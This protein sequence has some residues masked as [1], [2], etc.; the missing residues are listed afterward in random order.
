MIFFN[1]FV[2]NNKNIQYITIITLGLSRQISILSEIAKTV[3]K[4][5]KKC[6]YLKNKYKISRKIFSTMT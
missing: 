5:V 2:H 3:L 4:Y 1:Q 6:K